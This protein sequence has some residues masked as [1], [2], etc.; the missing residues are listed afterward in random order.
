MAFISA[1]IF[2]AAYQFMAFMSRA[3][4][5]ESGAILDS[6]ND[7]NIEGGIAE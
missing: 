3:K 4:Y 6:G 2:L 5:S 1:A 7:L